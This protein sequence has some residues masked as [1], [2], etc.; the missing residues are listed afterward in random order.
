MKPYFV[1]IYRRFKKLTFWNKLGAFGAIA[2]IVG[3]F[4]FIPSCFLK[5]DSSSKDTKAL[6]DLYFDDSKVGIL[7]ERVKQVENKKLESH[8]SNFIRYH[9]KKDIKALSKEL[10]AIL[11]ITP[12]DPFFRV[13]KRM[14]ETNRISELFNGN[15]RI[16]QVLH[17]EQDI[18][19]DQ[20][21][22]LSIY[23][24]DTPDG[25]EYKKGPF[26]NNNISI[27]DFPLKALIRFKIEGSGLNGSFTY[28][29]KSPR[30]GWAEA[31]KENGQ[32]VVNKNNVEYN[33]DIRF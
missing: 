5:S 19:G 24:K 30:F 12:Y 16:V 14:I 9:Q 4:I 3:L 31:I 25:P 28:Y 8:I 27:L 1:N 17:W 20:D 10:K 13:Y 29:P 15:A 32:F 33:P 7:K 6:L 21:V 2:S 18:I 23:M 11:E 22:Y 26:Y